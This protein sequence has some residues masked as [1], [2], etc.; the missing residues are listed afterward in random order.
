[1]TARSDVYSLYAN[2]DSANF[3][4]LIT[5]LEAIKAQVRM[6]AELRFFEYEPKVVNRSARIEA[7]SKM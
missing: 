7:P 1:M 2:I 3:P 5:P 4:Y 6:F